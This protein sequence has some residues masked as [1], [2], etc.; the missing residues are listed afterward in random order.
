MASRSGV[1]EIP[2][3]AR[4]A[5]L[6]ARRARSR[7]SGGQPSR[8]P[9]AEYV[10]I[11]GRVI[12]WAEAFIFAGYG[13]PANPGCRPAATAMGRAWVPGDAGCHEAFCSFACLPVA[14]L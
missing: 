12:S 9:G 2:T 3:R 4:L 5:G 10:L 14:G 8:W 1:A 13:T 6:A 11:I 7:R